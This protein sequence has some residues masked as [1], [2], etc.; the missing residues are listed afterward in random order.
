MITNF[1]TD[2]KPAEMW[3]RTPWRHPG[4]FLFVMLF[5]TIPST[6]IA[7][8]TQARPETSED[9]VVSPVQVIS[10]VM[11]Q[12]APVLLD[13]EVLFQVRGISAYPAEGRAEKISERI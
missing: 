9:E 1:L 8:E 7:Q 13:G 2:S 11:V 6:A 5:V 4:L 10:P 3:I 12:T